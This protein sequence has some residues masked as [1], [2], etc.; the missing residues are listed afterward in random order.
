M[1]PRESSCQV[2]SLHFNL[3]NHSSISLCL[4]ISRSRLCY[5]LVSV[6]YTL[7]SEAIGR[8]KFNSVV[9]LEDGEALKAI[10]SKPNGLVADL[11]IC[12]N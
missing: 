2:P 8:A 5:C 11:K 4:V 7:T 6:V 12:A 3:N 10:V 1:K 9:V